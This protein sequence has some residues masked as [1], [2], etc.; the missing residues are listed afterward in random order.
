MNTSSESMPSEP[1]RSGAIGRR[2]AIR[3]IGLLLGGAALAGCGRVEDVDAAAEKAARAPAGAAVG[4]FSARDVAFLDEI[5]ETIVP[6]TGTPGAKDAKVG[7]FMA[8]MV[9]DCYAPEEQETFRDGM[10]RVDEAARKAAGVAFV[11]ATPQQRL[12]VLT[13]FDRQ[14]HRQAYEAEAE[15]RRRKGLS[16]LPPYGSA[17]AEEAPIGGSEAPAHFF[18]TMKGLALLGY[19]TSEIGC[20]RALRYVEVPGRY[21]PCVPYVAGTPAW[22]AHA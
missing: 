22:A 1:E 13:A 5:A 7:A 4:R 6:A 3:R 17:E 10:R 21:D 12:A 15:E 11:Q 16:P 2:E 20:T 8:L 18:R 9:S 19:F 14:A